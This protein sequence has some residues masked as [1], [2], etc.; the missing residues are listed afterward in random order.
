MARRPSR[1][2]SIALLSTA[3]YT[4]LWWA[5]VF[6]AAWV[7]VRSQ[8]TDDDADE[9][10]SGLGAI[11]V[12]GVLALFA[13]VLVHVVWANILARVMPDGSVLP[14]R[15][16]VMTVVASAN[17]LAPFAVGVS[18]VTAMVLLVAVTVLVPLGATWWAARAS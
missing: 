8:G 6:A 11:V 12:W 3:A 7:T 16:I 13:L 14:H 15:S 17:I 9:T 1:P 4:A 2:I 5:A 18:P 10:D